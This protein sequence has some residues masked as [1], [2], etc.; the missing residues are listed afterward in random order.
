ML[1]K[2]GELARRSVQSNRYQIVI[3]DEINVAVKYGLVSLTEV[4]DLIK[5]KPEK[6]E[7]ILTGR[8]ANPEIVRCADLV[9]EMKEKKHYF[10]KGENSRVGIER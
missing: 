9:T 2:V 7:L 6:T 1:R 8:Y 4:L 5:N 10:N 3:L